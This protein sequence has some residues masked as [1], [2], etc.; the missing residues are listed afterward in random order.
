MGNRVGDLE[1]SE[2]LSLLRDEIRSLAREAV[3]E[4]FGETLSDNI[5][6]PL[7]VP[8]SLRDQPLNF[9]VDDVGPCRIISRCTARAYS[10]CAMT[11]SRFDPVDNG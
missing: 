6:L 10:F 7:P 3:Q 1:I 5:T 9:P 8:N 11:I 4:V 2:L